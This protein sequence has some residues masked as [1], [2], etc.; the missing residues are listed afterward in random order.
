MARELHWLS[1]CRERF[2]MCYY[3]Q[4]VFHCKDWKWGNF[5]QHCDREYRTGETCGLKLV[6]Q[7]LALSETCKA[8]Q[9]IQAKYRRRDKHIQDIKRWSQDP[10]RFRASIEK[11]ANEIKLLDG[12]IR[13][14]T[15]EKNAKYLSVGNHR[16]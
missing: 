13:Q 16:R 8:C 7:P 14:I 12:E 2:I 11:A 9:R 1:I 6:Y 4:Y 10:T 5:R 15:E 3:D